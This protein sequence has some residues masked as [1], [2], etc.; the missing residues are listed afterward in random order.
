MK[1]LKLVSLSLLV[2]LQGHSQTRMSQ[3]ETFVAPQKVHPYTSSTGAKTG[4]LNNN[5]LLKIEDILKVEVNKAPNQHDLLIRKAFQQGKFGGGDAGGGN[6]IQGKPIES[7]AIDVS[8][9]PEMN[10]AL[11]LAKQISDSEFPTE[12]LKEEVEHIIKSKI[13]YLVPLKLPTLLNST[14][15]TPFAIEQGALQD[16]DEVWI[17]KDAFIKMAVE[18]RV[19]LLVHEIF[20]GLKIFARESFYKQCR[21]SKSFNNSDTMEECIELK[22]FTV[23][24]ALDLTPLDYADVRKAAKIT[25]ENKEVLTKMAQRKIHGDEYYSNLKK[26]SQEVF[27]QGRFDTY[28]KSI[29][30]S[31]ISLKP[32][33]DQDIAFAI[34]DKNA[35]G[36]PKY[37]DHRVVEDL[38]NHR[39]RV[40]AQAL[41][42]YGLDTKKNGVISLRIRVQE[43]KGK[44]LL[45]NMYTPIIEDGTEIKLA[46][47]NNDKNKHDDLTLNCGMEGCAYTAAYL[48]K[49]REIKNSHIQ[50]GLMSI[51]L[52]G[53]TINRIAFATW[54][55]RNLE[56]NSFNDARDV[57]K[58]LDNFEYICSGPECLGNLTK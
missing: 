10:M 39:F 56:E 57:Y 42:S 3:S 38:G 46:S 18:E 40:Q 23:R 17:E 6:L 16:F 50:T 25:L 52:T 51:G 2:A 4:A 47:V 15:G 29:S 9:M 7:Y 11:E 35:S 43:V 32:F 34:I 33:S 44:V 24:R 13:W 22:R 31:T 1:N 20:M 27:S 54:N 48:T 8:K 21:V 12:G 26:L 53:S 28:Y 45:Q 55:I 5:R 30:T 37:C 41:A 19:H 14:V 58:C 49:I 36:L